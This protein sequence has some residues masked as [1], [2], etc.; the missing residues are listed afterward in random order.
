M[1]IIAA[2][3]NP[4]GEP[5]F[6]AVDVEVTKQEHELGIHYKKARE[7]FLQDGLEDPMVLFDAEDISIL[8]WRD[9]ANAMTDTFGKE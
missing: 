7:L 4:Q 9:I 3:K 6:A 1:R 5:D 2:C 8:T